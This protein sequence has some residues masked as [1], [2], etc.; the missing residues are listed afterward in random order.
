MKE[1]LLKKFNE[2]YGNNDSVKVYFA[3]GRVNLIG[4]HIDYNGG[5]VFPCAITL[6]THAAAR[7]RDDDI[8]RFYS[9]N[10]QE[11]GIIE[12]SIHNLQYKKED[13]WTNYPKGVIYALKE[14]G[15]NL[16]YGLDILYYGNLPNCSGLSS[17][18]SIE[19][20]TGFMLKDMFN[21]DY[22]MIKNA[23]MCQYAENKFIGVNCGIMDQ[24]AIA[25]GKAGYG[26]L[27]NTT[28]LSYEYCP[29]ELNDAKIVIMNTLKKRKLED[30]KYN[31]RRCE[32]EEALSLLKPAFD[33]NFLCQLNVMQ[34]EQHKDL[35]K[36]ET[37]YKRAKHAIHENQRTLQAVN[38]LKENRLKEF[39]KL[40][41]ASH[42]SLRDNYEVTGIELDTLF[43]EALMIPGV[44]G[45][46]MTGAGF[47][48]CAISIVKNDSLDS[49]IE[50]VGNKYKEKIGHC[51]QF[52]IADISDGPCIL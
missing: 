26:I 44:V 12:T 3:P 29:L 42:E 21:Y 41:I 36:N 23:L 14:H 28:T 30:S 9:V 11:L 15:Y 49:F 46:R 34:F 4:E 51:C 38:I 32:C 25:M 48:G 24:F 22:D 6:G 18:A 52:Y 2:I 5:Y 16:T 17:S 33:I 43:E 27:L 35:I 19:V 8:I 50:N 37:I 47:G 20:L 1:F 40:M 10:F 7:K 31:E 13:G 45:A 39:G